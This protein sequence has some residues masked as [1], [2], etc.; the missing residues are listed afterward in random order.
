MATTVKIIDQ[1]GSTGIEW[2]EISGTDYGTFHTFADNES[3]GLCSDG[4]FGDILDC[5]GC[6]LTEG[7]KLWIAVDNAMTAYRK[8]IVGNLELMVN[9]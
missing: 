1:D 7:D 4:G 3:F 8:K 2:V 9:P 5:D 6:P